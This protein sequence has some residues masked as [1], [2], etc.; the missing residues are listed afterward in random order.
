MFSTQQNTDQ[1]ILIT[2]FSVTYRFPVAFRIQDN[3]ISV[4]ILPIPY[5]KQKN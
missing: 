2:Y 5:P 1:Q 3:D 4:T